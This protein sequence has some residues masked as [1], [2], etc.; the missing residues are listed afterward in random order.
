MKTLILLLL[1]FP[2]FAQQSNY[3]IPSN[4][5]GEWT[6]ASGNDTIVITADTIQWQS[7][8]PHA[9]TSYVAEIRSTDDRTFVFESFPNVYRISLEKV[10][11]NKLR[12]YC[13]DEG[14]RERCR[15][16]YFKQV[17]N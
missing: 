16:E 2:L 13:Q 6:N 7:N 10:S 1:T 4:F 9:E 17:R 14:G 3:P 5:I 11:R 15:D 12:L 8:E